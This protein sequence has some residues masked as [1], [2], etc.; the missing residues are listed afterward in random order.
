[1]TFDTK[2]L[3]S[4]NLNLFS[5]V[6]WCIR[7]AALSKGK[8]PQSRKG[9]KSNVHDST[10]RNW[11]ENE[12]VTTSAKS[13]LK[14]K[15]QMMEI[16]AT[17][18]P[19]SVFLAGDTVSCSIRFHST[20]SNLCVAWA[21]VQLQCECVINESTSSGPSSLD[22]TMANGDSIQPSQQ[23]TSRSSRTSFRPIDWLEGTQIMSSSPKLLFCELNL[24]KGE[25]K[26]FTYSDNLPFDIPPSFRGKNISYRYNLLIGAQ[27]LN[28]TVEVM[29]VPFRVLTSPL[30]NSDMSPVTEREQPKLSITNPFLKNSEIEENESAKVDTNSFNLNHKSNLRQPAIYDIAVASGH[31]AKLSMPR[32]VFKMGEEIVGSLKFAHDSDIKCVQYLVTLVAM[33]EVYNLDQGKRILLH[34]TQNKVAKIHDFVMGFEE[35]SLHLEVPL[36]ITPT[37]SAPTCSLTWRLHFEFVIRPPEKKVTK[38]AV[39]VKDSSDF[40]EWNAP[41]RMNVQTLEWNLPLTIL[42]SDPGQVELIRGSKSQVSATFV[43]K[44][45]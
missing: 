43:T 3:F 23:L 31:I 45:N 27:L 12:T 19:R 41:Q 1:M 28:S 32:K 38:K 26:A 15:S 24:I 5:N 11:N 6:S 2:I 13:C 4:K 36:F 18:H 16:A 33:E 37:F 29:K 44:D 10:D 22:P 9:N 42:A 17:L 14:P 35:T 8:P 30:M 21:S 25:A 7:S 20:T 34:K 40:N 39:E